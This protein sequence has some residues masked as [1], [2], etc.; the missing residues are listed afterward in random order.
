VDP[1]CVADG[2]ERVACSVATL[3][4]VYV[5]VAHLPHIHASVDA[6]LL[7]TRGDGP[8][9]NAE[10]VGELG[11]RLSGPVTGHKFVHLGVRQPALD[12]LS[13]RV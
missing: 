9:M 2:N 13:L 6:A 1:E 8:T 3:G 7:E 11:E 12:R 4:L 5:L 10:V